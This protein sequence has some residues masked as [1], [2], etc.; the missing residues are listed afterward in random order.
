MYKQGVN[1]NQQQ[2]REFQSVEHR[3]KIHKR[4][5]MDQNLTDVTTDKNDFKLSNV[6]SL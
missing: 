2:Q 4:V 5:Q 3:N 1:E 6:M